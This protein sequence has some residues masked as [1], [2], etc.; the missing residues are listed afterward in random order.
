MKKDTIENMI[1]KVEIHMDDINP[2]SKEWEECF[3]VVQHL[4]KVLKIMEKK[5]NKKT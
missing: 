4:G 5:L 2:S 3:A 1:E